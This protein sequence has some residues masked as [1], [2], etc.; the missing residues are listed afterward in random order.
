MLGITAAAITEHE[1]N[2]GWLAREYHTPTALERAG[3]E[4]V[5]P[6]IANSPGPV[7]SN[8]VG[9]LVVTGQTVRVTDP[10]TMAAEVRLG[11]WDDALLVADMKRGGIR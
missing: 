8:N 11:R 6:F 4:E 9:I 5:A 3:L 7:Y 1:G 10:F 2:A